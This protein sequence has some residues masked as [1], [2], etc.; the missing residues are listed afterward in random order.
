MANEDITWSRPA[1]P[2]SP[3]F[4]GAKERNLVKQINDE[5]T[6]YVLPQVII[7][8]P[9]SMKHSN[10]H[11]LYGEAIEKTYLPPVRVATRVYWGDGRIT[12]TEKH[13][14]DSESRIIVRFQKRRIT[15]DLDLFVRQGDII[16]YGN[17]F[18]EIQKIGEPDELF[19]QADQRFEITAECLRV[20]GGQ[21]DEPGVVTQARELFRIAPAASQEEAEATLTIGCN[22]QIQVLSARDTSSDFTTV[23]DMISNPGSYHGCVV[24]IT[25]VGATLYPPFDKANKLYFNEGGTWFASPFIL[26]S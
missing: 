26:A 5:I 24:Y 1:N 17:Q 22:G 14:I 6:E 19:G 12:T 13:N 16:Y 3:L 20:R 2:P 21:F 10:F 9:I 15:E 25:E 7:Y 8:Y 18:Y 23:Q 4:F 11:P